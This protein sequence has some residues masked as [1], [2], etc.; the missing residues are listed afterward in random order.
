MI[1][2]DILRKDAINASINIT[3]KHRRNGEPVDLS[4]ATVK[5]YIISKP[6]GL[7]LTKAA[8]FTTNGTDGKLSYP[9]TTGDLDTIGRY[10]IQVY[11][12]FPAGYIGPS[13]IGS[14][15]VGANLT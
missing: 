8:S 15:W 3:L 14:F 11:L 5:N 12:T 2:E 7:V 10:R 6:N 9:T 4:T 13:D 1:S